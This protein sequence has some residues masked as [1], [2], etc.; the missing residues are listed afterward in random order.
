MAD[1]VA[2]GSGYGEGGTLDVAKFLGGLPFTRFHVQLLVICSLVTF[3][4]G[5]DFSLISFTLPYL[6]DEMG[7]SDAMTGYVSSAAFLGQMIGSLV[8]SYLADLVRAPPGD[9]LVH[10]AERAA[11][12]RHRLRQ[13]A[14]DA[15]RAAADRR[16]RDRRAA[17][18]G[19]VDQHRIDARRQEGAAR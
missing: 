2:S 17:R 5:L 10:R 15:D 7:L 13:H 8:G 14:R 4:D 11:D 16:P 1:G 19:L 6:R 9:H 3:F 18:P 12:F